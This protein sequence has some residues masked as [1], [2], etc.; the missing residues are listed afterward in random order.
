MK[1]PTAKKLPSGKWRCQVVVEGK[2]RSVTASTK[3]EAERKAAALKTGYLEAQSAPKSLTLTQAIDRY[4][5]SRSNVL[6]PSTIREYRKIPID[7]FP[8][9]MGRNLSSLTKQEIQRAVDE[10]ATKVSPKT[11]KNAFSLVH[12]ALKFYG[13]ATADG[14]TLPQIQEK[15][16]GYLQRNEIFKLIDAVKGDSCELPILLG[17]LHGLRRSEILGLCWDCVDLKN[18]A[19]T[20]R[21]SYVLDDNKHWVLQ[22]RTKTRT[23]HR[24]IMADQ[25]ILDLLQAMPK[26]EGRIVTIHPSTL[27][28]HLR[29]ACD[30]IGAGRTSPHGLRHTW[31]AVMSS[32]G[33]DDRVIVREGGWSKGHTLKRRYDYV[34]TA[35]AQ[36]AQRKRARFFSPSDKLHTDCTRGNKNPSNFKHLTGL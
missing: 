25:R 10:E 26:G 1:I 19:L 8:G 6:S 9:L 23:S 2:R 3:K 20:I 33:V 7:R 28:R 14:V 30:A 12:A 32:L 11:V 13:L 31:A 16:T 21:R 34:F 29:R 4:I 36:E 18:G 24:T 17:L 15:E 5:D 35:E 27:D 22:D